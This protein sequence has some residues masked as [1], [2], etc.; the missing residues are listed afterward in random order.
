ML[1]GASPH[2]HTHVVV[3]PE[4][5]L[6]V[7]SPPTATNQHSV[8]A[9][10]GLEALLLQHLPLKQVQ[11]LSQLGWEREGL[12]VA[13]EALSSGR[14]PGAEGPSLG[15]RPGLPRSQTPSLGFWNQT[16]GPCA[17]HQGSFMVARKKSPPDSYLRKLSAPLPWLP[18]FQRKGGFK[19]G[20]MSLHTHGPQVESGAR[21]WHS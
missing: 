19:G 18:S 4:G 8:V 14:D 16:L 7:A 5:L 12:R 17:L 21:A 11:G 10:E 2:A 13:S 20:A 6:Q 9:L 3:E 1:F 15:P